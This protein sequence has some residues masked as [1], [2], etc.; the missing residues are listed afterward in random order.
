MRFLI[1]AHLGDESA[2]H[3]AARLRQRHRSKVVRLTSLDEIVFAPQWQHRVNS[4]NTKTTLTLHDGTVIH[5]DEV[6]VVFNRLRWLDTPFFV[7][8]SKQDREYAV[9]EMFGLIVSWLNSLSC[10]VVNGISPQGL[11]AP[12]YS[13]LAWH[14]L[15][16]KA[17]L[18]TSRIRLTSST[19]RY[20]LRELSTQRIGA[21]NTANAAAWLM[22]P[23]SDRLA[24]VCVVGNHVISELG[25]EFK[26]PSLRLSSLTGLEILSIYFRQE[27]RSA[28]WT[29]AGADVCPQ[30]QDDRSLEAVVELLESR[31]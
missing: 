1:L 21:I 18:P 8:A 6:Q 24:Q 30:F 17:G 12:D 10:P 13:P 11:G 28:E 29:F 2:I 7:S 4:R 22:E 5:G 23:A 14:Y 31:I 16:G 3:V 9:M 20:P 26:E 27:L 15:A 25:D 19:R